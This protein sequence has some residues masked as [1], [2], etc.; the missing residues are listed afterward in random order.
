[1]ATVTLHRAQ[2]GDLPT[3]RRLME[4]YLYDFSEFSD[5]PMDDDG[6]LGHP[7]WVEEQLGPAHETYL[8]YADEHI[9]GFAIVTRGSSLT[10]D[11]T[12]TDLTQFFIVRG[13]RRRS[14]GAS[15]AMQIFDLYPGTWEVRVIDPN[16]NARAFWTK[17]V[18]G[19][20]RGAYTETHVTAQRHKGPV[21]TFTTPDA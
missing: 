11:P 9:A 5:V 17:T 15:A 19:Y 3:L 13:W 1:M 7:E 12:I 21:F 10:Q 18:K 20:T 14:I 8:I 6:V 2:P 4:F 16:T